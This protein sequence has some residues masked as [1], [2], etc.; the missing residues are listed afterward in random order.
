MG[1]FLLTLF[2]LRSFLRSYR[3]SQARIDWSPSDFRLTP[4]RNEAH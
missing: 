2:A 1:S 4:E 3:K